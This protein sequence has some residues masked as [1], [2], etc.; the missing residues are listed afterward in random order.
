MA[1]TYLLDET[2]EVLVS[3]FFEEPYSFVLGAPTYVMDYTL[4]VLI[5]AESVPQILI[6]E[7]E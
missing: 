2:V 5:P 1:N 4:E 3:G 7:I 6:N